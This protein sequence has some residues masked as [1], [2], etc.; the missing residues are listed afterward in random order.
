MEHCDVSV[1]LSG[2]IAI[3]RAWEQS[4]WDLD[5]RQPEFAASFAVLDRV[6]EEQQ[7]RVEVSASLETEAAEGGRH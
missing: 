5:G 6:K 4:G 2:R 7:R 3:H 1:I